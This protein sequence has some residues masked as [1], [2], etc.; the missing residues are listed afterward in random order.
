M[1]T[2]GL[3]LGRR[4][5][6]VA[7]SDPTGAFA[8]ELQVIV[9]TSKQG[10]LASLKDLVHQWKVGR[11]IVGHPRKLNGERG[12]EARW[13]ERYAKE[14]EEALGLPVVLWDEWLSTVQAERE[15]RDGGRRVKRKEL[16][17][18]AAAIILQDYLD[19]KRAGEQGCHGEEGRI[20]L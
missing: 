18:R 9:R 3:D 17:A 10:D 8:R 16:H 14:L 13:A 15:F 5:I 12:A 6:G 11:V 4:R 1:R 20:S 7:I 2:L 19:A